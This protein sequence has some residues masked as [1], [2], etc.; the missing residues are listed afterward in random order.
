M[1]PP[2][3]LSSA[4]I[5]TPLG[6]LLTVAGESG[7]Y[8]ATFVQG[9][10]EAVRHVIGVR[11]DALVV[12][13]DHPLLNQARRQLNA[14]FAAK[15]RAFTLDLELHG[16]PF[17][18]RVW[19]ALR[20]IPYGQRVSYAEV[21][22]R[23]G[24]PKASRAVAQAC[25]ANPIVIV[26][27]C[28]RVISSDGSLGGF[29][30]GL[31]KKRR[32][33]SL[34]GH[35]AGALPLFSVAQRREAAQDRAAQEDSV[36]ALIPAPLLRSLSG[37]LPSHPGE[38]ERLLLEIM[39]HLEPSQLPALASIMAEI[40]ADICSEPASSLT[41]ELLTLL[42][43]R[44]LDEV[45]PLESLKCMLHAALVADSPTYALIGRRLTY[46]PTLPPEH[47][48]ELEHTYRRV[49]SGEMAV[50]RA[51]KEVTVDLWLDLKRIDGRDPWIAERC[52]SPHEVFADAGLIWEAILAAEDALASG[53]GDRLQLLGQL[54]DMYEGLGDYKNA[55]E[56]VVAYAAERPDE[57]RLQQ[58][59]RITE[60][61]EEAN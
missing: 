19:D 4:V 41:E 16:T 33:L 43:A 6:S 3:V 58:L 18:C 42:S 34:E 45:P 26:V 17:Q 46:S 53:Q 13:D 24:Q 10:E 32:L 55:Y 60:R 35:H 22:R 12:V 38:E 49:M 37:E 36:R 2:R 61:I 20:H 14:Y 48:A 30:S 28:H 44:L 15:R 7:L 11:F 5:E 9:D 50:S 52:D 21:A 51:L 8:A 1:T 29:S 25:G 59:R 47:R 39:S 40:A 27:P 54:A 31:P 23:I 57:I 56:H